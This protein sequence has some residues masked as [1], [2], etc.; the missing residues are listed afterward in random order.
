MNTQKQKT[1]STTTVVGRKISLCVGCIIGAVG[2][3]SVLAGIL[4]GGGGLAGGLTQAF[5]SGQFRLFAFVAAGSVLGVALL[6]VVLVRAGATRKFGRQDGTAIIEFALVLPFML[7]L[8]LLMAQSSLLMGGY[9]SVN[10]ASY[11]AARA[12]IVQIPCETNSEPMNQAASYDDPDASGKLW[13]IK[14]AAVWGLTPIS[15]GN[16]TGSSDQGRVL[17]DG[18]EKF[19]QANNTPLPWWVNDQLGSRLSYAQANTSVSLDEPKDGE[20]YGGHEDITVTVRY[21][22]Y[23]AIPYASKLLAVLD[24]DHA[25][26]LGNERHA[27]SVE[28]PC[29]LTNDGVDDKITVETEFFADQP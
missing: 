3:C 20:I 9:L 8:I 12:A 2:L 11:C 10:Y 25:V 24:S 4:V 13:R 18:L 6:S 26:D 5:D 29:T 23:L 1:G 21:N 16:L 22:I 27:L 15:P 19:F 7:M 28:I 14:A 17:R